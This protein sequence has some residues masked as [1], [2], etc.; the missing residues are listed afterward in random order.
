MLQARSH[1]A[2]AG[3]LVDTLQRPAQR[4]LADDLVHAQ[5]LRR[6]RVAAQRGDVRV[7]SVPGQQPQHQRAQ[8]VALVRG[9]AAAVLQRAA[10]HPALEHAGGGQELG[11]EHQLP[12]RRGRRT[13]IP[14]HVHAPAQGVHHL[15]LSR[16]IAAAMARRQRLA[17]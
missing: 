11:K 13:L 6:H 3:G 14:A 15:R 4:I 10:R 17:S 7:A 12:M 5:R 9:I 16:L 8:H 2:L 1:P